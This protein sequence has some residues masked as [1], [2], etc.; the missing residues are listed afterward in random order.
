MESTVDSS[1]DST[2][3][4]AQT[5]EE[6][7]AEDTNGPEQ[8]N[9]VQSSREKP[10]VS[11]SPASTPI[12]QGL[13]GISPYGPIYSSDVTSSKVSNSG[14]RERVSIAGWRDRNG[15]V[16][17]RSRQHSHL[18]PLMTPMQHLIP[19]IYWSEVLMKS[20][21]LHLISP[22]KRCVELFTILLKNMVPSRTLLS[23]R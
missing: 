12:G 20:D 3:E 17:T 21:R 13:V 16:R 7:N 8:D 1:N 10:R 15:R 14:A 6:G 18:G 11:F 19:F 2:P 22:R 5:Y 4:P 23:L 9:T